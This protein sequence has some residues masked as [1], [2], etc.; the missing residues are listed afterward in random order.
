MLSLCESTSYPA[1]MLQKILLLSLM[2]LLAHLQYQL[3]FG[4]GSYQSL[5][6]MQQQL[7][8]QQAIT[9][10]LQQRNQALIAEVKDLKQG[11]TVVEEYARMEL[12]LIKQGEVFYQIVE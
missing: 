8:Q 7:A 5:Q 12:G 1:M 9:Q 4:Q 6:L 3:W 2:L 10:Q 11:L